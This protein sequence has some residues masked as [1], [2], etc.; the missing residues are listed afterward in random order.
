MVF[1]P[2]IVDATVT[3][4]KRAVHGER[5]WM[6]H[7]THCYQRLVLSGWGHRKT[8]LAEYGLM[9]VCGALAWAYQIADDSVRPFI[10]GSWGLIML[11]AMW[12]VHLAERF[13]GRL[14]TES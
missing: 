12:A 11:S 6:A 10:L 3:L 7:R 1:S 13:T 2:F 9:V 4:L 14:R 5:F 8:V